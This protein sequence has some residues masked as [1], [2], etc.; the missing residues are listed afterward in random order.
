MCGRRTKR[1]T[2]LLDEIS[3][4]A[5][6]C[7]LDIF[8]CRAL[9]FPVN[10]DYTVGNKKMGIE[11]DKGHHWTFFRADPATLDLEYYCS[12]HRRGNTNITRRRSGLIFEWMKHEYRIRYGQEHRLAGV[13]WNEVYNANH[14]K[15]GTT[16]QYGVDCLFNV[17]GNIALLAG[18]IP[19]AELNKG[20][21]DD[22]KRGQELRYRMMIGIMKNTYMFE[23]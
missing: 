5:Q 3:K 11:P 1:I 19:V 4:T 15:L 20:G 9:I 7:C 8:G 14:V 2:K 17:M 22:G 23:V 13:E 6:Q 10:E 12:L 21:R 16:K 18:N